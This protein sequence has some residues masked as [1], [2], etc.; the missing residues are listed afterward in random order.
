MISKITCNLLFAFMLL[1]G[2]AQAQVVVWEETFDG[3]ANGW[4][5]E[6]LS[7]NDTSNWIWD[8]TG[9]VGDG[10]L[11]GNVSITSP[12]G[13]NGAMVFNADLFTTG[14]TTAPT[15]PSSGYPKYIAEL[16]SPTIDLSGVNVAVS[17]QF[18][19][20]LRFLNISPGAVA[21]TAY[22]YSIDDG[23]TW[24]DPIVLNGDKEV[25]TLYNDDQITIPVPDIAGQPAV[26]LKFIFGSDFYFWV[27]D[28]VRLVE[29]DPH[30]MRVNEGW[31]AIAPNARTPE[32][33]VE[34]FGF[35][36]DVENIGGSDQ[37]NVVLTM[38][39]DDIASGD[40]VYFGANEYGTIG[41][42]SL[43]ENVPFGTFTPPAAPA[44]YTAR[45]EISADSVDVDPSDNAIDW[46]FAVSDTVFAKETAPIRSVYPAA[47]NWNAGEARSWAYGNHYYL[48]NGVGQYAN[49]ITFSLDAT[50]DQNNAGSLVSVTLYEWN[51]TNADGNADPD[52]RTRVAVAFYPVA[53]NETFGQLITVTITDI[54]TGFSPELKNEQGYLAVLEYVV[55][56]ETRLD[57]GASGALDYGAMVFN[58]ELLGA[59]RY[60][61]MLGISGNLEDE[62]YSSVGFGRDLVPCVRLN[63]GDTPLFTTNTTELPAQTKLKLSPNP[64][65]GSVLL[66]LELLEMSNDAQVS[67]FDVNGRQVRSIQ[68]GAVQ[69]G[70][71]ELDLQGLAA[72]AYFVRLDTE[73][74]SKVTR[75]IVQ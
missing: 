64:A 16:T 45:Y 39:I 31:Y 56:D 73:Q 27:V 5:S 17:L 50:G 42:D 66:S 36:A 65:Q 33:Q 26:R 72:G 63:I 1:G 67:I 54:F 69:Q 15:G 52:E 2:I 46:V 29:R 57:F 7:P 35:M 71:F 34:A 14:G 68:L 23:A 9:F 58:S 12:T 61:G 13:S 44:N 25:N 70:N 74:G 4:T 59:P 22:A 24:S 21:R 75:L 6:S 43:A 55:E 10:L 53:G 30:N 19:Q 3:S 38:T 28:D 62:P 8:P 51:D 48:K 47:G 40:E 49:S 32:S 37:T 41:V 11:I 18:N 20:L 60:A